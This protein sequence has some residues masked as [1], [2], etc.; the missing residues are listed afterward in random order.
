MREPGGV[1]PSVRHISHIYIRLTLRFFCSPVLS[2]FYLETQLIRGYPISRQATNTFQQ[3]RASYRE[4]SN[5]LLPMA[6]GFLKRIVKRVVEPVER[7]VKRLVAPVA[8]LAPSIEPVAAWLV[9]PAVWL[10]APVAWLVA[11]V[12]PFFRRVFGGKDAPYEPI[13]EEEKKLGGNGK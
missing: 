4:T 13:D 8:R 1:V 5:Y 11:P 7:F 9:A 12:V 6:F 2:R 3:R 10:A